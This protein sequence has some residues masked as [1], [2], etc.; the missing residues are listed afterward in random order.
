[1]CCS[2]RLRSASDGANSKGAA[3][4]AQNPMLRLSILRSRET[5]S[6]LIQVRERERGK[7][8]D[9]EKEREREG[10][11]EREKEREREVG[12]AQRRAAPCR[13]TFSQEAAVKAAGGGICAG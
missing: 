11:R 6:Q 12:A 2:V 9:R 8:R 4:A 7:E 1:M 5:D 10:E 3:P 13:S